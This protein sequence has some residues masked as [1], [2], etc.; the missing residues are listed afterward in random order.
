MRHRDDRQLI[1]I[2]LMV[3]VAY[4]FLRWYVDIATRPAQAQSLVKPALPETHLTSKPELTS[5][6]PPDP[7]PVES[8]PAPATHWVQPEPSEGTPLPAVEAT[9]PPSYHRPDGWDN[10]C[11]RFDAEEQER[12]GGIKFTTVIVKDYDPADKHFF[13]YLGE[14]DVA[15]YGPATAEGAVAWCTANAPVDN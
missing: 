12:M 14:I 5:I 2:W 1:F 9:T 4:L 15:T 6:T 11:Y 13:P 3:L 8:T 10:M 7:E